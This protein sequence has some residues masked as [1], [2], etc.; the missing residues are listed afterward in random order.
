MKGIN[1][2]FNMNKLEDNQTNRP[3]LF[4]TTKIGINTGKEML[5]RL[6]KFLISA[7]LIMLLFVNYQ[8]ILCQYAG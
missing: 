8:T 6:K 7:I 5:I 1:T 3:M 2:V 4:G